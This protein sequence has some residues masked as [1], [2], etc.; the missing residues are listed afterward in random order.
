[1]E[2]ETMQQL[3]E[4]TTLATPSAKREVRVQPAAKPGIRASIDPV[5]SSEFAYSFKY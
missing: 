5:E 1:M 4:K 2:A 3:L